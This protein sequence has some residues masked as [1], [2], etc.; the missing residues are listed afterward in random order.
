MAAK[1]PAVAT[2]AVGRSGVVEEVEHSMVVPLLVLV[3]KWIFHH[4]GYAFPLKSK[5]WYSK[6]YLRAPYITI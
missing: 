2:H 4:S 6:T 3:H 1:E 5:S